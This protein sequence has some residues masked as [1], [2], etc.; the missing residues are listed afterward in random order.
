MKWVGTDKLVQKS[1]ATLYSFHRQIFYA[2]LVCDLLLCI[3]P[4]LNRRSK[5]FIHEPR[6]TFF[7]GEQ[8]LVNRD[9]SINRIILDQVLGQM[10]MT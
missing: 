2:Y 5:C 3:W 8:W 7:N 6:C 4:H 1:G 9:V 10:D